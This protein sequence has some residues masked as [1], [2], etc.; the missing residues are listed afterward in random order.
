MKI[1]A[2]EPIAVSLPMK[3]PVQMA[4]ETVARADNVLVRIES[5]DGVV[6][7]GEAASAP[8]MTGETV[9]S[10]MAA[11]ELYDA[12]SARA[13]RPMISPARRRRWTRRCTAIAAPKPPSRSR[14]TISSAAPPGGRSM[15]CSAPKQRS[16]MPVLAVIGSEDAAADLREAQQR[17]NAG[18]RAFKIKVGLGSPEAD[19]DTHA[20]RLR[21]AQAPSLPAS[22]L[23]GLGRRQSRVSASTTRCIMCARSPIAGSISSSSR[24]TRTIS[25]AWRA[26][27]PRARVPIGADEG[28]HSRD[29]IDRHHERK[30]ARGVSLKAI[31]LGGLRARARGEPAVRRGSAC[32]V[33]ISC[34]TGES[35]IASAAALHVAA[36]APADR[37]GPDRD[38]RRARRGCRRRA[39]SRSMTAMSKCSNARARHRGR[40]APGA[41]LP[42]GIQARGVSRRKSKRDAMND[43]GRPDDRYRFIGKPLPRKED[44]RLITG[45]GRFTDDFNL[46]GQAYAVMVRSPYP[47]ARIVAIDAA[48]AK[49]MPGVLGVFTGADLRGR[50]A[51][52]DS[53]RSG[54][55]DQ[56]RHEA[57]RP[58]RRHG[59][60]RPARAA[61]RRQGAP[62]RRGRRD[63]RRRN[64]GAGDGCRRSGRGPLRGTAFR[65]AFR[66]RDA[67]RRAGAL[68]RS[69][70]QYSASIRCSAMPKRPTAAFA[71]AAHVVT[72]KFHVGRV[73]G[74]PLEPRAA[75]GDYDAATGRYTLYAG[76]GGAVRQKRELADGARHSRRQPARALARRRRQFRHAQSRLC[77]IRSGAVGVAKSSAGR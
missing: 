48:A 54:A 70:G 74:V 66:R 2:I 72:R 5:D 17:W 37:L 73:T 11:I 26:S 33:N 18:Y 4:G 23:P 64:Q 40:R 53:A 68:G 61:A 58:R 77:R 41:A 1:K 39:A 3:K 63:G 12:R 35:S 9:A 57:H 34:K 10:M 44:E 20:Q 36:V 27:P 55:E 62:C 28:I 65:A 6:G 15:R 30:A 16:R 50:R 56:I 21:G 38:Q 49:A 42:A 60:R 7:W 76:S 46:D 71:R 8:T 19:A 69:A 51:C 75:L 22:E 29:D 25:T 45:K 24:S 31:K 52:A 32:S 47:H 43:T 14:C 59:L 13:P 67:A